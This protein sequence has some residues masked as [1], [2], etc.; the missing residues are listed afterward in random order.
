MSYP[1]APYRRIVVRRAPYRY[2]AGQR[3]LDLPP[4]GSPARRQ[5]RRAPCARDECV[6]GMRAYR[7]ELRERH[8]A[9]RRTKR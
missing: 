9:A 5:H 3:K 6:K 8:A 7:A 4:H 1:R 2:S